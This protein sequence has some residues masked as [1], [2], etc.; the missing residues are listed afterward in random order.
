MCWQPIWQ[1]TRSSIWPHAHQA[2]LGHAYYRC[3]RQ[4]L[5]PLSLC[6]SVACLTRS[7]RQTQS[8]KNTSKGEK[9][10]WISEYKKKAGWKQRCLFNQCVQVYSLFRGVSIICHVFT[11]IKP[12]N[13]RTSERKTLIKTRTCEITVAVALQCIGVCVW[14]IMP[15]GVCVCTCVCVCAVCTPAETHFVSVALPETLSAG[16]NTDLERKRAM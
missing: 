15:V 13:K 2:P 14:P 6:D 11:C 12:F 8:E 3:H 1:H 16:I 5:K 9:S 10:E 4:M 7:V